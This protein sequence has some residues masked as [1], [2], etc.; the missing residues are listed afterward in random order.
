LSRKTLDDYYKVIRK[1]EKLGFDFRK[2]GNKKMGYLRSFVNKK[3]NEKKVK[4]TPASPNDSYL[5]DD[6]P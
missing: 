1:A 4:V 2:Y 6:T 3:N 5:E